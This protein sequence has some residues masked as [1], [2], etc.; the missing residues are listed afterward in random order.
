[1]NKTER[2]K[3]VKAMEFV[4]RQIND[5]D[6]FYEWVIDGV[7]DGD[8]YYGDLEIGVDEELLEYYIDDDHFSDLMDKFIHIISK[9]RKSGG[10][11]CD[12]IVS[13]YT[14]DLSTINGV[15]EHE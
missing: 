11:Y 5:N 2:I 14:V 3:L 9:A 12:G 1:M 10:L 15:K 7:A 4:A 8:I 6:I 13:N